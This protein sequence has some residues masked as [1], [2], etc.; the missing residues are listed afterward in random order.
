MQEI[1]ETRFGF[2]LS[3]KCILH[4][5]TLITDKS[6]SI[7]GFDNDDSEFDPINFGITISSPEVSATIS[8]ASN[9]LGQIFTK[10]LPFLSKY[11]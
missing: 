1:I 2:G 3:R 9:F 8:K 4:P 11:F 7:E 10:F 5:I 6:N